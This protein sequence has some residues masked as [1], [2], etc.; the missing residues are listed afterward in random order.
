MSRHY[1]EIK[2]GRGTYLDIDNETYISIGKNGEDVMFRAD[3]KVYGF[4]HINDLINAIDSE[5]AAYKC[6]EK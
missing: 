4:D 1:K 3:G 2:N 6:I 5:K